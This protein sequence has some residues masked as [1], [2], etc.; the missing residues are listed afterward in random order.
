MRYPIMN[1]WTWNGTKS[2]FKIAGGK[3]MPFKA[4]I[5]AYTDVIGY[6]M[7]IEIRA[8][9]NLDE[10]LGGLVHNVPTHVGTTPADLEG[11]FWC[12]QLNKLSDEGDKSYKYSLTDLTFGNSDDFSLRESPISKT[13]KTSPFIR[14]L[15]N[16][17]P[18]AAN[19]FLDG[20]NPT[21][22]TQ[23]LNFVND[24][25][26]N[27]FFRGEN[28]DGIGREEMINYF[29]STFERHSPK[30][31]Q[32]PQFRNSFTTASWYLKPIPEFK[33]VQS[34]D[35]MF[36][37]YEIE[38]IVDNN[39]P[40]PVTAVRQWAY[41]FYSDGRED[42][43]RISINTQ[44]IDVNGKQNNFYIREAAPQEAYGFP[45]FFAAPNSDG[46]GTVTGYGAPAR[47]GAMQI[48]QVEGNQGFI[49][50]SSALSKYDAF[51]KQKSYKIYR[52]LDINQTVF[53]KGKSF[54]VSEVDY[55]N[56]VSVIGGTTGVI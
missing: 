4:Q 10:Y 52:A 31:L 7:Y 16:A 41:W 40:L 8:N 24:S 39:T 21:A 2:S 34:Y 15:Q 54:N 1:L 6:G 55:I 36:D 47:L 56:E 22:N 18:Q 49:D 19:N 30:L 28:L 5:T 14:A 9:K 50:Y 26:G 32:E 53:Y 25:T 33:K 37:E 42:K 43:S 44:Y 23:Y 17:N 27:I 13:S 11:F 20:E 12:L 3:T 45:V 51:A 38:E 29:K 48:L 35:Y 46:T